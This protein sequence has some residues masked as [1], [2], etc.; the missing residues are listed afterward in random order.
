[1]EQHKN[2]YVDYNIDSDKARV[3]ECPVCGCSY[4]TPE[5]QAVAETVPI[6]RSGCG[7]IFHW[8]RNLGL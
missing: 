6:C 7:Y 4:A 8:G 5:G 3:W 2:L 1:M